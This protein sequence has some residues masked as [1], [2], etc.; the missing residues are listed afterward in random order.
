MNRKSDVYVDLIEDA[1][2]ELKELRRE[3][4]QSGEELSQLE[5]KNARLFKEE[6]E[7]EERLRRL[8]YE[9]YMEEKDNE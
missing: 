8:Q 1:R 6:Q 5:A 2:L 3:R 7:A 4:Y 9:Y